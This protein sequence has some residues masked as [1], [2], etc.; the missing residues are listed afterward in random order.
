MTVKTVATIITVELVYMIPESNGM[1][2]YGCQLFTCTG[3]QTGATGSMVIGGNLIKDGQYHTLVFSVKD[4]SFWKGVI[5]QLRLDFFNGCENGDVMYVKSIKLI[6]GEGGGNAPA[7]SLE[8]TRVDF[9]KEGNTASSDSLVAEDSDA[10][11]RLLIPC[12]TRL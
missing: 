2:V 7:I 9:S 3:E 1:A 11:M 12:L 8:G 6:E 10:H 4:Y 5:H